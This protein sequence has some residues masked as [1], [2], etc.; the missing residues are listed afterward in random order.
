MFDDIR[1]YRDDEVAAVITRLINQHGLQA[2]IAK[3]KMPRLY[4]LMPKFACF[5]VKCSLKLRAQKFHNIEQIQIEVSK[6]LHHLIKKSTAGFSF[7]GIEILTAVS[8]HYLLVII[9]ISF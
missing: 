8:R 9:E 2:S 4:Q 7:S 1:P 6:Y 3:L 5:I